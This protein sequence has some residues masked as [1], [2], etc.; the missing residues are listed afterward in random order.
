MSIPT[1]LLLAC[2]LVA[3]VLWMDV[4]ATMHILRDSISEPSQRLMQLLIVWLLPILGAI[5]VFAVHRPVEKHS[6]KYR[7]LPN[8]GDDFGF[9]RCDRGGRSNNG[10]DDD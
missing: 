6:G 9:P 4:K 2:A 1:E 10:G 8:P 3:I 7:E 5:I